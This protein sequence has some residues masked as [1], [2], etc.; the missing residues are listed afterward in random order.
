[1]FVMLTSYWGQN[2]EVWIYTSADGVT[3]GAPALLLNSTKHMGIGYV[4]WPT[5]RSMH[6][7]TLGYHFE[8]TVLSSRYGQVIGLN[9]S[10]SA[11]QDATLVYAADPP[12]VKGAH[13]DFITR[14]I[15]FIKTDDE[16]PVA[17]HLANDAADAND[18]D[19]ADVTALAPADVTV[20][21]QQFQPLVHTTDEGFVSFAMDLDGEAAA[22][23]AAPPSLGGPSCLE[24][25]CTWKWTSTWKCSAAEGQALH[26]EGLCRAVTLDTVPAGVGLG[27]L[28]GGVACFTTGAGP[29]L[30]PAARP[31]LQN[32]TAQDG[33]TAAAI[34]S[35]CTVSWTEHKAGSSFNAPKAVVGGFYGVD[36]VGACLA[37]NGETRPAPNKLSF[38]IGRLLLL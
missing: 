35:G 5:F 3:W 7:A 36:T 19:E 10:H 34:A 23:A 25:G 30:G 8:L 13:R 24:W 33:Y 12:T 31:P 16:D 1:M 4:R 22:A 15:H 26:P 20:L 9:S 18:D 38:A 14:S 17:V 29:G 11:G 28:E 21:V 37:P 32:G 2:T 27:K 6:T